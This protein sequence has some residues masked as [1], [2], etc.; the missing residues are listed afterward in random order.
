[1]GDNYKKILAGHHNLRG[2]SWANAVNENSGTRVAP[3]YVPPGA[4]QTRRER[5]AHSGN[6]RGV[7]HNMLIY[8]KKAV[9]LANGRRVHGHWVKAV[10]PEGE[11]GGPY[12]NVR[13]LLRNPKFIS[14]SR[15]ISRNASAYKK[16]VRSLR[17]KY[18]GAPGLN[19]MEAR[20]LLRKMGKSLRAPS[21]SR[22]RSRSRT[23]SRS[24][25][26]AA[27]R[28]NALK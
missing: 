27:S 26:R 17:R 3:R 24:K 15:N 8:T 11:Y 22:S 7:G 2:K 20:A 4:R 5:S 21:A 23:R 28:W 1:M 6:I 12:K 14:N 19:R 13:N 18:V 10:D 16:Y 9:V 25:P